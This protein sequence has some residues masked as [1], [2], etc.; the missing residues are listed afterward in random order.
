M[1]F[2]IL[3]QDNLLY[4]QFTGSI[5]KR[6]CGNGRQKLSYLNVSNSDNMLS[7]QGWNFPSFMFTINFPHY[8]NNANLRR[9]DS[10]ELR[11]PYWSESR[12]RLLQCDIV[13]DT[14]NFHD[15][16]FSI[17]APV[18]PASFTSDIKFQY[19]HACCWMTRYIPLFINSH[20]VL[21]F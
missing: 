8:I 12:R 14:C 13:D 9:L 18:T 1:S 2:L 20:F 11:F 19:W 5:T 16:V 6:T 17:G 3:I 10:H 21:R 4:F 15:I 7:T